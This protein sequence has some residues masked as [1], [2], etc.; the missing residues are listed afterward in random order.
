MQ[1][2]S[3]LIWARYALFYLVFRCFDC[4][5]HP[6]SVFCAECFENGDHSNHRY[7]KFAAGGGNCDCGN[8]I[9]IKKQG[10]CKN[11]TG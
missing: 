1:Q 5:N 3:H 2:N 9:P 4:S 7:E 6:A 11:H 10:F 8:P